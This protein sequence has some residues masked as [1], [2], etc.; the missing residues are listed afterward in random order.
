MHLKIPKMHM[1][2]T[3]VIAFW[4]IALG[5]ALAALIVAFWPQIQEWS[6]K[7][8]DNITNFFS[9]HWQDVLLWVTNAPLAIIKTLND[10]G[11]IAKIGEWLGGIWDSIKKLVLRFRKTCIRVDR[12]CME[13][14]F[15]FS[16]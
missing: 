7:L 3:A 14:L 8:W 13:R 9:E 5:I 12:K 10:L 15:E 11:I 16:V 1:A 6:V 4:P 2:K